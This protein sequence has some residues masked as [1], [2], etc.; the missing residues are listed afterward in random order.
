M[1]NKM[2]K[3]LKFTQLNQLDNSIM[4]ILEQFGH[5]K[6]GDI[7]KLL[8]SSTTRSLNNIRGRLRILYKNF[9]YLDVLHEQQGKIYSLTSR[10]YSA[11]TR[12]S[13]QSKDSNLRGISHL[14]ID[15]ARV[16]WVL[17][18]KQ[19]PTT[20]DTYTSGFESN[21]TIHENG[22]DLSMLDAFMKGQVNRFLVVDTENLSIHTSATMER[23][24]KFFDSLNHSKRKSKEIESLN[25]QDNRIPS[26]IQLD[27]ISFYQSRAVDIE[28]FIVDNKWTANARVLVHPLN[29]S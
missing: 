1:E 12:K 4:G 27:V 19:D 11:Y 6:S 5:A 18:L 7:K 13:P 22:I 2:E 14:W 29:S 3:T 21:Q 28:D 26:S 24:K 23:I 8:P 10:G 25:E 17:D 16:R 9:G 20:G 15:L